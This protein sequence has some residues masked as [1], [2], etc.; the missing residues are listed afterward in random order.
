MRLTNTVPDQYPPI[1]NRA[2]YLEGPCRHCGISIEYPAEMAGQTT[3]CPRC[4]Q[5]TDLVLAA[6]PEESFIHRK[7]IVWTVA[8]VAMLLLGLAASLVALNRAEKL[9][10]RQPATSTNSVTP[11]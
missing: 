6:P 3:Q 8:T 1:V 4:G 7:A 11:R 10:H 2:K 5:Q 9:L